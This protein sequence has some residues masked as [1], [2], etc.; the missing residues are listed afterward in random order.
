MINGNAL[1]TNVIGRVE[2]RASKVIDEGGNER[3]RPYERRVLRSPH[4]ARKRVTT[5]VDL[6]VAEIGVA[7]M[8]VHPLVCG[9][10]PV[11]GEAAQCGIARVRRDIDLRTGSIDL[12]DLR[13][14][15]TRYAVGVS[16]AKELA[17]RL[18]DMIATHD[19]ETGRRRL[20]RPIAGL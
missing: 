10:D 20:E 4:V 6:A 18:S 14:P 2:G 16:G 9:P 5:P 3:H 7:L 13:P 19:R 15:P 17:R 12:A 8:E 11:D 1:R